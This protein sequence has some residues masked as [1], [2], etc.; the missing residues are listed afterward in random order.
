MTLASVTSLDH[1]SYCH[2][3]RPRTP[4][5][6]RPVCNP[7]RMFRATA[8]A[9]ATDLYTQAQGVGWGHRLPLEA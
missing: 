6:T 8:V 5:R 9:S 1:T 4:H 2:L 3:R 7:T